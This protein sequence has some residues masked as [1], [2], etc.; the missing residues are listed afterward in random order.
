[1]HQ[2][3]PNLNSKKFEEPFNP[4][5]K[6]YFAPMNEVKISIPDG[7]ICNPPQPM[8]V[9]YE[10]MLYL[11]ELFPKTHSLVESGQSPIKPN[12]VLDRI[13][14][15]PDTIY[16]RPQVKVKRNRN[17]NFTTLH[18]EPSKFT[19]KRLDSINL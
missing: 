4:I 12:M 3:L 17:R 1:M 19:A 15:T 2:K 13:D 6:K 5:L 9:R 14:Q 10:K 11:A 16:R 8:S 18:S 7:K